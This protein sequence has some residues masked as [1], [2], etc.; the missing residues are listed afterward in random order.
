[1]ALL[2]YFHCLPMYT[3]LTYPPSARVDHGRKEWPCIYKHLSN[4]RFCDFRVLEYFKFFKTSYL[5]LDIKSETHVEQSTQINV[6]EVLSFKI[7]FFLFQWMLLSTKRRN[8]NDVTLTARKIKRKCKSF[9]E[10]WALRK[11][12]RI[13]LPPT[14]WLSCFPSLSLRANDVSLFSAN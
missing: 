1:M 2:A 5:L 4:S 11:L 6:Q 7:F 8:M 10:L 3:H 9:F 12:S 13:S 14:F